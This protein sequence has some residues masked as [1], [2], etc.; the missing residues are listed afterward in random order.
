MPKIYEA[1]N[2]TEALKLAKEFQKSGKYNLFRGQAQNWKVISTAGRLSKKKIEIA[3]EQ[4]ER[5]LY[6]FVTTTPL[7]KYCNEVDSFFAIAQH[8]GIPTN[9]IDFTESLEVAFYF[10]TNS[11]SNKPKEN[12][13]I[14]CLNE[15]DLNNFV[16][17]TNV[18]YEKDGVIPPYIAKNKVENLWRLQAQKGCLLYTPYD[19]IEQLYNF[20]KI[21]FPFDSPYK[22]ISNQDIYPLRKSELEIMLDHYFDAERLHE[23]SK[24]LQRFAQELKIPIKKLSPYNPFEILEKKEVHKS[25]YS[26]IYRKWKFNLLEDWQTC[27]N[28]KNISFSIP[29]KLSQNQFINFIVSRLEQEYTISKIDRKTPLNFSINRKPKFSKKQ[30]TI[31]NRSCSRIW[32]GTRN[33]PYSNNEIFTIIG[34]YLLLEFS[35]NDNL[36]QLIKLEMSNKYG[37]RLRFNANPIDIVKAYRDDIDKVILSNLPRPIPFELLQY[38]NRPRYIFDF[39]KLIE[40]FKKEVVAHQVFANRDNN[41]PVIFY[42]PAQINILGYA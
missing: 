28:E 29:A 36:E 11:K 13:S 39:K 25:W 15:A 3:T 42:T 1:E 31:V 4:I 30:T 23:G 34:Q 8:Y 7:K 5:L 32:D 21:L 37:S 10:A 20:D 27:Q 16:K 41:N 24:K 19:Q 26:S 18:L 22:E 40:L 33:L 35:N 6:Y 9:Y 17:F 12:C 2:I 14:I 38:V